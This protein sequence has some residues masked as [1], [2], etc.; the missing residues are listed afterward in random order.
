METGSL[1]AGCSRCQWRWNKYAVGSS[2]CGMI[3][4][5]NKN[6][7]ELVCHA[8]ACKKR[9]YRSVRP[10]GN[11]AHVSDLCL[12]SRR[13]K[14]IGFKSGY[15]DSALLG[16]QC[17]LGAKPRLSSPGSLIY[18]TFPQRVCTRY[19]QVHKPKQKK[20]WTSGL[21]SLRQSFL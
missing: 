10:G 7:Q 4:R 17:P 14:A 2:I 3:L 21:V 6:L 13:P 16:P 8:A 15:V 9:I 19:L 1:V 12:W 11:E 5:K 18:I 20:K